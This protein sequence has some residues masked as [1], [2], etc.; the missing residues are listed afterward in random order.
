MKKQ[1]LI[2]LLQVAV[3]ENVVCDIKDMIRFVIRQM[4]FQQMQLLIDRLYQTGLPCQKVHGPDPAI[5]QTAGTI[6]NFIMNVGCTEHRPGLLGPVDIT[7]SIL[8]SF[9]ALFESF[10]Y[11]LLHSKCLFAYC[12]LT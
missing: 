1:F 10:C 2:C 7:K 12:T 4:Q 6:S 3:A 5:G 11:F 9:L 8:N